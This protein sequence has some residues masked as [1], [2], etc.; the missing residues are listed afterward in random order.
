MCE[1]QLAKWT[2]AV[3][4]L[5]CFKKDKNTEK[6]EEITVTKVVFSATKEISNAELRFAVNETDK[7]HGRS[8][9]YQEEIPEKVKREAGNWHLEHRQ[10]STNFP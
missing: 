4:S 3:S 6:V 5:F 9:K 7:S 1:L 10:P 8:K 2:K